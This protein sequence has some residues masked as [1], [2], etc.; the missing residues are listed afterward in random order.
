MREM[1]KYRDYLIE[2]L[3]NR[4]EAIGYFQAALEEY[5]NDGDTLALLIA[6]PKRRRSAGPTRRTRQAHPHGSGRSR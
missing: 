2:R 5:Q 6:L 4:E 3:S 1:R